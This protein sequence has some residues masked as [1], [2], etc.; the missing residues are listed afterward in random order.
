M[1]SL[2]SNTHVC[3]PLLLFFQ[4]V[5]PELLRNYWRVRAIRVYLRG[6]N[7]A[8]HNPANCQAQ[9]PSRLCTA[10]VACDTQDCAA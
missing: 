1:Q 4:K 5:L 2:R 7:T 3:G 6:N 9:L 10:C 8:L